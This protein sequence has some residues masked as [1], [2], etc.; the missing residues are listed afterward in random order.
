VISEPVRIH[1]A[2]L[3]EAEAAVIWYGSRSQRA[4]ELFLDELDLAIAQIQSHRSCI[5]HSISGLKDV[6]SGGF[7]IFSFFGKARLASRSLRLR[8]AAG[9]RGIGDIGWNNLAW[10]EPKP[11]RASLASQ[12]AECS[13]RLND[14]ALDFHQASHRAQP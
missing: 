11:E 14:I 2:A 8:T 13:D 6:S 10:V 9:V 5:R 1:P 3:E 7:L 4:A 12:F